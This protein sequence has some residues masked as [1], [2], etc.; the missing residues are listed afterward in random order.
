MA[1]IWA[2]S[3]SKPAAREFMRN[4]PKYFDGGDIDNENHW[5]GEQ[6]G[7]LECGEVDAV[8]TGITSTYLLASLQCGNC[9]EVFAEYWI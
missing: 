3:N 2:Q 7:C 5:Y 4:V 1:V 8:R 9:G 6:M